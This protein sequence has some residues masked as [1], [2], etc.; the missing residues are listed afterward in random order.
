MR[1]GK[2]LIFHISWRLSVLTTLASYRDCSA[3]LT[4]GLLK[5]SIPDSAM[6]FTS[7]MRCRD[8]YHRWNELFHELL[9]MFLCCV[10]RVLSSTVLCTQAV[11]CALVLFLKKY[12]FL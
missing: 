10:I 7:V 5:C 6:F 1:M 3:E 2:V 11:A 4:S 8:V 9:W 12:I